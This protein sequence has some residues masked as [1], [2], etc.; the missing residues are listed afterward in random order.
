MEKSEANTGLQPPSSTIEKF[1][2]VVQ[3]LGTQSESARE[4]ERPALRNSRDLNKVSDAGGDNG[5]K[6]VN[7]P[8]KELLPIATPEWCNKFFA[9]DI[10]QMS[11]EL[12]DLNEQIRT[13]QQRIREVETQVTQLRGLRTVLLTADGDALVDACA[14]V[15]TFLSWRVGISQQD[16]QELELEAEN[17]LSIARVVCADNQAERAQLGQL[18]ISQTRY[19]CE[20]GAEPKGIL[21]I[22]QTGEQ[23]SAAMASEYRT[24]L[25]EYAG[26]KNVCLMT[27][28]QLLAMYREIVM[29]NA[30]REALRQSVTSTNGWLQGFNL[31]ASG[32]NEQGEGRGKQQGSLLSA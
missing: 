12:A 24:E 28:Q 14:K 15:L 17:H 18:S 25:A 21:I 8:I 29:N 32:R 11:R 27:T 13:A 3:G 4:V 10:D 7:S 20:R 31:D 16:K 1:S 23:A 9:E 30:D 19:W 2:T 22:R 6:T 26:R 5:A